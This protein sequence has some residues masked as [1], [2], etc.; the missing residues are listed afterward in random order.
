MEDLITSDMRRTG[1]LIG[2]VCAHILMVWEPTYA[3]A[4]TGRPTT[5]RTT[6]VQL[7]P[8][9]APL[10]CAEIAITPDSPVSCPCLPGHGSWWGSAAACYSSSACTAAAALPC[11]RSRAR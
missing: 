3:C 7:R 10:Y 11:Q 9:W 1:L 8:G 6:H 4:D 5:A 2:H